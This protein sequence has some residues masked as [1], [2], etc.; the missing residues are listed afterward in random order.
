ME[1]KVCK[2]SMMPQH[3]SVLLICY[4]CLDTLHQKRDAL[5]DSNEESD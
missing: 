4:D 2:R 3:L 5:R 1:C